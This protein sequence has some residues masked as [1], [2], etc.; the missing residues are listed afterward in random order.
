MLASEIDG[1]LGLGLG[2][3]AGKDPRHADSRPVDMEHD[4]RGV[5][6]VEAKDP[7]KDEDHELHGGVVVIVEDNLEHRWLLELG[8]LLELGTTLSLALLFVVRRA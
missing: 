8:S 1:F 3:L 5:G 4:S 6:L 7:L 2:N